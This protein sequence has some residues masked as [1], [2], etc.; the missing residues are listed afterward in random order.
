MER[1]IH[2]VD[3]ITEPNQVDP[4]EDEE[5]ASA[6]EHG[7]LQGVRSIQ[8]E[9]AM[10]E[11]K[12]PPIKPSLKDPN[13]PLGPMNRI[14]IVSTWRT[15]S[16]FLGDLIQSSPGVFYSYEP[17]HFI[18]NKLT[19]P[20]WE[21]IPLV[22]SIFQCQFPSEYLIHINGKTNGSQ[23]FM[24]RN[25]RV[26]EPC[27]RHQP[28][29]VRPD[30]VRRLCSHLAIQLI[31]VVRLR[32]GLS[33]QLLTDFDSLKIIYL[34]RD[35][36]GTMASRTNLTWCQEPPC[37]DVSTLCRE[38]QEDLPLFQQ[39]KEKYPNQYYFL[40]FEDLTANVEAEA[41]K[42]FNFL[43]LK[44]TLPVK[45]FLHTHTRAP[46]RNKND[47]YSTSRLSRNISSEWRKKMST[48][49]IS[50]ISNQ[51]S[52]VLSMLDYEI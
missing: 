8:I 41:E 11:R 13:S 48:S 46:K 21:P 36:R 20:N 4:T 2:S 23:N 3:S 14:L 43:G 35:P 40:K 25:R 17:L 34:V 32:L 26:W 44:V 12:I 1:K 42:L 52:S 15:G 39:L 37:N 50:S 38:M 22:R 6:F 33:E 45:V 29:C 30:F 28:L 9:Q 19:G 16:S 10:A 18:E 49:D 47:P 27:Y 51:C 31:K 24:S 7:I 5:E